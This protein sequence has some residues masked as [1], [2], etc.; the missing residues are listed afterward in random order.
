MN[1]PIKIELP[2]VWSGTFEK[3]EWNPINFIV[4][5]NGTG[6]SLLSDKLYH[7]LNSKGYNVRLLSAERLSGFENQTIITLPA[8]N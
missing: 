8:V 7:N 6:K 4:G 3:D 1:I 5:P 2:Q